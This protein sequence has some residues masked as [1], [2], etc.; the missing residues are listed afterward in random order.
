MPEVKQ[1]G[2]S[3][4]MTPDLRVSPLIRRNFLIGFLGGID[5]YRENVYTKGIVFSVHITLFWH[6]YR[7]CGNDFGS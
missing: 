5:R 7:Y 4:D 3:E 6:L 2:G 1:Y